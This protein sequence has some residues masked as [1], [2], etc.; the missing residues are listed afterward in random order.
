VTWR[1]WTTFWVL[2]LF[3]GI[4][5]FFI[6]L[7][8]DDLSPAVVAWSRITLAAAVLVPIAW[9][10]GTLLPALKHKGAIVAFAVTEL[11]FP[12]FLISQGEQWISSSLAGVLIAT[13]PL[14]V[15]IIAP[16]F[17]V[18]EP[19]SARRLF[20]LLVGLLGVVVLL[21]VDTVS[22][23]QQWTGVACMA[24]AVVGYAIGPLV[25]QRYL[26]NADELGALACSLVAAS[27]LLL[28]MAW[29]TAP[30]AVPSTLSLV[31]IAILGL[32]CTASALLLYFYL[33]GA[34]GAARASVIAY[35]CPAV[36]ALLGVI[37][38]H[39]DFGI[40]SAAGLA[41]I[42]FGSWLG[43]GGAAKTAEPLIQFVPMSKTDIR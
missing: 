18:R 36:A 11:V 35:I 41:I 14:T 28:P 8:L 2:C 20:G 27:L 29:W 33:I 42:L 9:R 31:S 1:T 26:S 22:G 5:Y 32:V 15:V 21:G 4:P 23:P 34:A 12:F 25:V 7:A 19:M 3:W 43:T 40:G 10:R 37:V 13:V 6:K 24:V 30:Q 16:L 38:L 17:G 39:E